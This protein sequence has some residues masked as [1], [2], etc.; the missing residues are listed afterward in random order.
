MNGARVAVVAVAVLVV[1]AAALFVIG[2]WSDPNHQTA[3]QVVRNA[4]VPT[5]ITPGAPP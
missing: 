1:V 5:G 2:P 3:E 4:G